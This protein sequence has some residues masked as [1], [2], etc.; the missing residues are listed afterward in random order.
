VHSKGKRVQW[1]CLGAAPIQSD[2][3]FA[4]FALELLA[5]QHTPASALIRQTKGVGTTK[6]QKI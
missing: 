5:A 2:V 1:S 6:L 3:E 4:R